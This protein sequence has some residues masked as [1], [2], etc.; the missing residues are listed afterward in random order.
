MAETIEDIDGRIAAARLDG[1]DKELA[2]LRA[3]RERLLR[4]AREEQDAGR[5]KAARDSEA[6]DA[7]RRKR[8]ADARKAARAAADSLLQSA[9]RVD[10]ALSALEREIRAYR[11]AAV[12]LSTALRRA[13]LSDDGRIA[14][15]M[16]PAARW[17][18]WA[19]AP[20]FAEIAEVPRAP[21]ARREGLKEVTARVIPAIEE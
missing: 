8:D 12:D 18:A 20:T 4:D 11:L 10:G 1:R 6:A 13:G 9:A 19:G 5:V 17:A 16:S 3:A 21:A 7:E 2:S 14:R 15:Q